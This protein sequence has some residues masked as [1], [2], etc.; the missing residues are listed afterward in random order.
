MTFTISSKMLQRIIDRDGIN[1]HYCG[2]ELS[3]DMSD[4]I[5]QYRTVDHIQPLAMGGSNHID[6]LVLACKS[7]NSKKHTKHYQEIRFRGE[8]N[9]S[10]LFLMGGE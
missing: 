2:M 1:C 6:N 9:A 4:S 7:C 8:V 5:M 3:F 10:L